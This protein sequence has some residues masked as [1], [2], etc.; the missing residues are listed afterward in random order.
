MNPS[1]KTD[2]QVHYS[3]AE[4]AGQGFAQPP[5]GFGREGSLSGRNCSRERLESSSIE[6]A[7]AQEVF[8]ELGSPAAQEP[9]GINQRMPSPIFAAK[10]PPKQNWR[11]VNESAFQRVREGLFTESV[12]SDS[13]INR[14]KAIHKMLDSAGDA[15]GILRVCQE[16]MDR[17]SHLEIVKACLRLATIQGNGV[18][19]HASGILNRLA[20]IAA[21]TSTAFDGEKIAILSW[22]FATLGIR[23][24]ALFLSLARETQHKIKSIESKDIATIAWS[25]AKFGYRSERLFRILSLESRLK[26]RSFTPQAIANIAL[27]YA[28]NGFRDTQ[29]FAALSG[30]AIRKINDFP[31]LALANTA[32]AFVRLGFGERVFFAAISLEA[33]RKIAEFTPGTVATMAWAFATLRIRDEE[34]LSELWGSIDAGR[35]ELSDAQKACIEFAQETFGNWENTHNPPKRDFQS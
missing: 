24:D 30:E 34:L 16:E 31:P 13:I 29:L 8:L 10:Q 19:D 28:R 11:G 32:W 15:E 21:E 6:Q 5:E 35:F 26:I 3:T 14:T 20:H 18:A 9:C 22:S 23:H 33:R 17:F 2:A 12:R 27:A 1:E 25:F 4:R 7:K